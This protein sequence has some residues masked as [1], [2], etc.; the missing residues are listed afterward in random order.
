MRYPRTPEQWQEA[1]DAAE[2]LLLVDAARQYGLVRG[3]PTVDVARCEEILAGG[4][5]RGVLP[6]RAVVENFI[7]DMAAAVSVEDRFEAN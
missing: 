7:L 2:V 1:A 5:Q 6:R 3:G 4:R